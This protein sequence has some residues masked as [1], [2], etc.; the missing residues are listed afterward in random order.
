MNGLILDTSTNIG[1][2]LLEKE[3]KPL[4]F[5]IKNTT[6]HSSVFVS[7][8]KE[9]I[10]KKNIDINSLSY[11]GVGIGPG[12]FT[13]IR[14]A[15]TIA[16]SL[17][18]SLK[19]PLVT[20]CSLLAYTPPIS[21]KQEE[22]C[23]V[24]DANSGGIYLINGKKEKNFYIFDTDPKKIELSKLIT[25]NNK[26]IISPHYCTL[27]N[28]LKHSYVIESQPNKEWLSYHMFNKKQ[29]KDFTPVNKL[30]PYYLNNC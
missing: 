19:L 30:S 1:Y 17:C 18:F 29:K 20:F 5:S 7:A 2:F 26:C 16:V 28:K 12:S 11:I 23:S 22:F 10:N 13:G 27:N 14:V 24:F 15:I 4:F 25:L 8:L 6:N 21:S 3:G 9:E